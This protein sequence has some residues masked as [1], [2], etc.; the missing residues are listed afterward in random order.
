MAVLR[1]FHGGSDS[2]E[3]TC[4][5]GDLGSIPGWGRF[6]G[7]GHGNPLQYSCLEDPYEQRSLAGC[8][9]WGSKE[10]D[11]TERLSTHTPYFSNNLPCSFQLIH[12]TQPV[13]FHL[14]ILMTPSGSWQF[15]FT[16]LVICPVLVAC[17]RLKGPG[18]QRPCLPFAYPSIP[19]A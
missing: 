18:R 7:G 9:P 8:S 17:A 10:L 11:T 19:S 5:L 16:T 12:I 13:K 1:G 4:N 14:A 6:L 15:T 2:K 3:P